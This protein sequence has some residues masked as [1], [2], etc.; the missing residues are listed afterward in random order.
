MPSGHGGLWIT[1]DTAF[2]RC[3]P[4]AKHMQTHFPKTC[5]RHP[6]TGIPDRAVY[7]G[8][9]PHCARKWICGWPAR[10]PGYHPPLQITANTERVVNRN[11]ICNKQKKKGE[12]GLTG[13]VPL[14]I[15]EY[16]AIPGKSP[17][18]LARTKPPRLS[19]NKGD[20]TRM[21]TFSSNGSIHPCLL[22]PMAESTGIQPL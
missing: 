19:T 4:A 8:G 5:A 15:G 11:T 2:R 13:T 1:G 12:G 10:Q 14:M 9:C 17:T 7:A 20:E 22:M 6:S 16:T 18:V 21:K 3:N